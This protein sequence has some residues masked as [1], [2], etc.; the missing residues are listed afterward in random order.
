MATQER[1]PAGRI[2]VA[3]AE[4]LAVGIE[5]IYTVLNYGNQIICVKYSTITGGIGD[6]GEPACANQLTTE[7]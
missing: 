5:D 2:N 6:C 4:A 3:A 7:T 1:F